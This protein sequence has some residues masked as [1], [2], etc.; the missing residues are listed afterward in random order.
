[1]H[2]GGRALPRMQQRSRARERKLRIIG[3]ERRAGR[4]I[5]V[6][7]AE[8]YRGGLRIDQAGKVA[9]IGQ[10]AQARAIRCM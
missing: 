10:E 5:H 1:M 9:T 4:S 8:N 6:A 7:F 2:A 3:D